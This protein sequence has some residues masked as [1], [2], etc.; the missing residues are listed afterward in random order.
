MREFIYGVI[1]GS[2]SIYLFN[3]FDAP[4]ILDYLNSSTASAVNSTSGYSRGSEKA[5]K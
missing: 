3:Y 4:G 1:L 5:K 2:A